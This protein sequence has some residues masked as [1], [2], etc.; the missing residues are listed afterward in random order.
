MTPTPSPR[1]QV[2]SARSK[3]LEHEHEVLM[4]EWRAEIDILREYKRALD[5]V[6][7]GIDRVRAKRFGKATAA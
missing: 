6:E 4:A 5:S 3:W 1:E 2:P 7:E